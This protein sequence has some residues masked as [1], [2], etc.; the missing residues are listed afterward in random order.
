[1]AEKPLE[2]TLKLND[3]FSSVIEKINKSLQG[4]TTEFGH[5][6]DLGS[7]PI[8]FDAEINPSF[9]NEVANIKNELSGL[10]EDALGGR[11]NLGDNLAELDELGTKIKST[12]ST[13]ES[14]MERASNA[15]VDNQRAVD[16]LATQY[17][18]LQEKL[19][20]TKTKISKLSEGEDDKRLGLELSANRLVGQL[21]NLQ[22][23]IDSQHQSLSQVEDSFSR[24]SAEAREYESLLSKTQQT[25]NAIANSPLV[26]VDEIMEAI[27]G[28]QTL[29]DK[30]AGVKEIASQLDQQL[31]L[32]SLDKSVG[33][34]ELMKQKLSNTKVLVDATT[35]AL[36]GQ[37]TMWGKINDKIFK[38]S[39]GT[40]RLV[41][42]YNKVKSVASL[43]P[44]IITKSVNNQDKLTSSVNKTSN[45]QD[46]LNR[47]A[48]LL[49]FGIAIGAVKRVYSLLDS[50]AQ[51][52][53]ELV[54][55]T[56]KVNLIRG[57]ESLESFNN[58]LFS[59]AND[60]R[61][62]FTDMANQVTRLGINAQDAFSNTDEIMKFANIVNKSYKIAGATAQE[63]AG[64]FLQLE[65]ALAQGVLQ[66]QELRSISQQAPQVAQAIADYMGVAR[67]ELK[68]LGADGEITAE[69]VKNAVLQAGDEID[70]KF[71]QIPMTWETMWTEAGNHATRAFMP[72]VDMFN[73]FI[74]SDLGADMLNGIIT[75]F[76]FLGEVAQRAFNLIT[77]G[78]EWV[79]NNMQTFGN[80]VLMVFTL[81][82]A[83]IIAHIAKWVILHWKIYAV[84][85]VLFIIFQVLNS[86][87]I[88]TQ[89]ILAY[90]AG[91][92]AWLAGVI[93]NAILYVIGW[94]KDMYAMIV[95]IVVY[96]AN[97][98][99]SVAEFFMNVWRNPIYSVR[100][101]FYNLAKNVLDLM[102]A[103]ADGFTG[104]AEVLA[105]VFL[106]GA[107]I[108]IGG[109]NKL[110]S[111]LN[112]IP[113][114]DIGSVGDFNTDVDF[115]GVGDALR[116]LSDKFD[117]GE[118][119]DDYIELDKYK[120]KELNGMNDA[121]D[122]MVNPN[123]WA[124]NAYDWVN[125]F[126]LGQ[127]SNKKDKDI[128]DWNDS[129]GEINDSIGNIPDY[130]G[131]IGKD[132]EVGDVGKI[133]SDVSIEDED[134]KYLR[135]IA[136]RKF[137][138]NYNQLTPQATINYYG[139]GDAMVDEEAL[140]QRFE[141]SVA[142]QVETFLRK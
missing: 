115:D 89:Q 30:L 27:A 126:S 24:L 62:A 107:N 37:D 44:N 75:A 15:V 130:S 108:A 131:A 7:T 4:L 133:K 45:A 71:Q 29:K 19:D 70:E 14:E 3:G 110:I 117:P 38:T 21:D 139:S 43:L 141:D 5:I 49:N 129:L 140:L 48:G 23:K 90:I 88:S 78:I 60:S 55:I 25:T 121:I 59:I 36:V 13:Y 9:K 127:F 77:M 52:A 34:V 86:L 138:M 18:L 35:T 83:L 134:L 66:G 125:N 68:Q 42:G 72:L 124:S 97:A 41:A 109:I 61:T 10:Q 40:N 123:D 57:E 51:K 95:N 118:A 136:E 120:Y 11:I 32:T 122:D 94:F 135:D 98:F 64:S 103:M 65:Q 87:G 73:E 101:L 132:K 142:D 63:Q 58:K 79:S 137:T 91:G 16:Q 106:K 81:A 17:N 119:P 28:A 80:I 20:L 102:G 84:V 6:Q 93:Y 46:K 114:V 128:E 50:S 1:M 76:Y 104:T 26:K 112:K 54:N 22:G 47:L 113:G 82:T 69:I 105:K 96:M 53:D 85:A 39:D 92:V 56:A 99:L 116:G 8:S 100:K 31:Y 67:G 33:K 74:N 111:A 2:Q 12:L